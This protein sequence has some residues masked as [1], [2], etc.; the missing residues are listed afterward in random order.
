MN[1]DTSK[2]IKSVSYN[3][4]DVP[5]DVAPVLLWT[6][7]SPAS[8]FSEQTLTFGGTY[9]GYI[10][11]V[12]CITTQN[13]YAHCYVKNG[14]TVPIIAGKDNDFANAYYQHFG[15]RCVTATANTLTFTG[16]AYDDES[17]THKN[18]CGVPTRIW[19]VKFTL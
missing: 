7:A 14:V 2:P 9:D 13:A 18:N 11:E 8:A 4:V 6:N 16:G 5:L 1:L 10:I 15:W 17:G 3:G 19:G 12:R